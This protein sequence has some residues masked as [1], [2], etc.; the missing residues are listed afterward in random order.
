M[1]CLAWC[2]WEYVFL[3]IQINLIMIMIRSN[4]SERTIIALALFC[5]WFNST[6][7]MMGLKNEILIRTITISNASASFLAF[8]QVSFFFIG[9]NCTI[10][11]SKT[12]SHCIQSSKLVYNS[13]SAKKSHLQNTEVSGLFAPKIMVAVVVAAFFEK[14]ALHYVWCMVENLLADNACVL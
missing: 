6:L 2:V 4:N 10:K 14:M 8:G 11:R 9:R 1:W 12:R 5:S 13:Q 7:T 3:Q